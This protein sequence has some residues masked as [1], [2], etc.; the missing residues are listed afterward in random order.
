MQSA[1]MLPDVAVGERRFVLA[2]QKLGVEDELR[3]AVEG[4]H[5]A[6]AGRGGR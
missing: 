2:G 5:E 4:D 6:A 3:N 1:N